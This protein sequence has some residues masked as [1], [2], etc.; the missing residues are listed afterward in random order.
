MFQE[1]QWILCEAGKYPVEPHEHRELVVQEQRV[2]HVVFEHAIDHLPCA[3]EVEVQV[4]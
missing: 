1:V 3:V 4:S 2:V